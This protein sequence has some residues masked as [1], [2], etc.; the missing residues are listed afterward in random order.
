MVRLLPRS[1]RVRVALFAALAAA[2][3]LGLG[4][5]W[6]V[7]ALRDGLENSARARASDKV[8]ALLALLNAGVAPADVPQ[9]YAKGG[10]YMISAEVANRCS[11]GL[12]KQFPESEPVQ[13]YGPDCVIVLPFGLAGQQYSGAPTADGRHYVAAAEQ[14]DP[15]GLDTV[16]TAQ[17]PAVGRGARAA[18]LVGGVAWLAVRRS[19][20]AVGAIRAEVDG[21]RAGDLGRRVPVPDSGDEITEL[22]VTMN[23]MLARLDQSVRRQSQFTA[24]AP[25]PLHYISR[26]DARRSQPQPIRP[27]GCAVSG[28]SQRR[29]QPH[30]RPRHHPGRQRRVHRRRRSVG[31][32]DCAGRQRRL[33]TLVAAAGRS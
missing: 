6:F 32:H 17:R 28:A 14:L 9:R 8:D 30:R 11:T 22:A 21:V 23:A 13:V 18:L 29:G 19:L 3:V 25:K 24:D 4:S 12:E 1:T 5:Y 10:G 7:N 33:R 20:R 26:L 31:G 16:D 2:L 27:Q 15:V